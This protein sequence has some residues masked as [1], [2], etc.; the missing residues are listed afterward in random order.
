MLIIIAKLPAPLQPPKIEC[1][2]VRSYNS[3]FTTYFAVLGA[4]E[5]T[6]CRSDTKC[7][8]VGAGV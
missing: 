8:E 6:E 3:C 1:T 7:V 4:P 5:N 2:N